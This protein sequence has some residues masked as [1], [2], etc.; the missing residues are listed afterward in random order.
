MKDTIKELQS[1]R[2]FHA[3]E[4]IRYDRVI[5]SM[6]EFMGAPM[7]NGKSKAAPKAMIPQKKRGRPVGSRN[8]KKVQ[9]GPVTAP[10]VSETGTAEGL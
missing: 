9:A 7:T 10:S 2:Q 6:Q 4:V 8:V 3:S 5:A 1:K